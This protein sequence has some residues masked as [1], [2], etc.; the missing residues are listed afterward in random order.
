MLDIKNLIW[1]LVLTLAT[2]NLSSAQF[3]KVRRND[4][5]LFNET[6][7]KS[8]ATFNYGQDVVRGV[9]LGGTLLFIIG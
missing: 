2:S 7:S 9:N 1:V 5:Q 4:T 6:A 8:G 3:V